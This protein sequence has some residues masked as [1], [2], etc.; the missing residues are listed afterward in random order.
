MTHNVYYASLV[1]IECVTVQDGVI[2]AGLVIEYSTAGMKELDELAAEI[3]SLRRF[4]TS[5][6]SY[7]KPVYVVVIMSACTVYSFMV[8]S[9]LA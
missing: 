1:V 4:I 7:Y 5:V 6:I 9:L 3:D 8:N 2:P